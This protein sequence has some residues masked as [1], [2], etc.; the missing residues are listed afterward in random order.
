MSEIVWQLDASD[1]TALVEFLTGALDNLYF[2]E[3]DQLE[4]QLT[5]WLAELQELRTQRTRYDALFQPQLLGLA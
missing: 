1:A 2:D 3:G 4:E 5:R